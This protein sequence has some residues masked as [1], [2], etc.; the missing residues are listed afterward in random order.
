MCSDNLSF[1]GEN[2]GAGTGKLENT[3]SNKRSHPVLRLSSCLLLPSG[4]KDSMLPIFSL[5]KGGLESIS[6]LLSVDNYFV[7]VLNTVVKQNY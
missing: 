6:E 2:G 5:V 4:N 7:K 1:G 3:C